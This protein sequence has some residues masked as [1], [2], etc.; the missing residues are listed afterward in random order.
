MSDMTGYNS[1]ERFFTIM[2]S[3]APYPFMLFTIWT[4][5]TPLKPLLYAGLI[6]YCSGMAAFYASI[7]TI[8]ITPPG[9]PLSAGLYRLSRNPVYVSASLV[10]MGICTATANL[11]LC[12]YL[13]ILLVFQHFMILAEE[14]TCGQKYGVV[15]EKY[16]EIVPRYLF[17]NH[18]R[19]K[20]KG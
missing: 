18:R 20:K 17:F 15:Y 2:A 9:K 6:L 19:Q 4:S 12:G 10:F 14:R 3:L 7:R 16:C 8:I 5:F 13:V 11:P 1:R